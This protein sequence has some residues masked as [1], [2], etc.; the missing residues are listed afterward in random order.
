MHCAVRAIYFG[1]KFLYL[2]TGFVEKHASIGGTYVIFSF[3][4]EVKEPWALFWDAV[5]L[6]M[7]S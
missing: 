3:D 4:F 2:P 1:G 5:V 7:C 6:T